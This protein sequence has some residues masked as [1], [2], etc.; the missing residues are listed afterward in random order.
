[1]GTEITLDI[2]EAHLT[3]AKNSRGWDH[4]SLFQ[5]ADRR[6]LKSSAID[7]DYMASEGV[8]PADMEMGFSRTLGE[9][10]PRLEMLGFTL[11]RV[12]AD[13]ELAASTARDE[14]A[15]R[16]HDDEPAADVMGFEAFVAFATRHDLKDLDHSFDLSGDDTA[17]EARIQGRF[18]DDTVKAGL[19]FY[20]PYS[21]N[22]WSERGYLVDLISVMH[23]YS[24]LRVLA[25]NVANLNEQVVWAYGMLV[26]NGW[27]LPAAFVAE[28][29][30]TDTFLVATEGSSDAHILKHA[31]ALLRPQIADFFRFIDVSER[32]PFSGTGNLLKFAEGLA[33]IDVHNQIVFLFDNDAEGYEAVQKLSYFPLPANMRGLLLPELEEFRRFPARGPDGVNLADINRRA[34]AIECYLDLSHAG[35][36]P[37]QVTWTNF[38]EA[39]DT[40][41]GA[42]DGKEAHTKP[43]LRLKPEDIAS[44]RYDTRKISLVLDALTT[45][46]SEIAASAATPFDVERP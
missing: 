33:K 28:A 8:D 37:P 46:C 24:V 3:Y 31:L 21:P 12:R 9:L 40:Y 44:G 19:P 1:M 26:E 6:R 34:A 17:R 35:K 5:E 29:R 18:G 22:A 11:A 27:A 30:R 15:Q 32:H 10:A 43:F 2:A 39:L 25:E 14:R 7:Y 45:L 41:Q 20:E 16:L 36:S 23:P 4:G 13:Y 38:K 42:L